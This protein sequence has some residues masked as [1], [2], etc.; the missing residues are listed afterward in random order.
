MYKKLLVANDGSAGA[1]RALD[2]GIALA[3]ETG[4]ELHMISVEDLP[5]FPASIDEVLVI[6]TWW[7]RPRD[8]AIRSG[9]WGRLERGRSDDAIRWLRTQ[10]ARSGGG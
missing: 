9:P 1:K 5:R 3:K 10:A 7:G 8:K 2:A 4:A 6:E